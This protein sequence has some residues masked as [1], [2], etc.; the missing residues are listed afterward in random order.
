MACPEIGIRSIRTVYCPENWEYNRINYI[1]YF[2]SFFTTIVNLTI[3]L[4]EFCLGTSCNRLDFYIQTV[5][6]SI[7]KEN[8]KAKSGD[9]V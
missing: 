9:N 2:I 7:F 4:N 3:I 6:K 8:R 5:S 1:I